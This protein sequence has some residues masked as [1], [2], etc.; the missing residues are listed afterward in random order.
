MSKKVIEN[1]KKAFHEYH[2]FERFDAGIVLVGT[3]IKSIRKGGV[4]LKDAFCKVEEGEL[5]LYSCHIA[6]YDKGNRFNHETQRVRKVLLHKK[7]IMKILG[8]VK[9]ENYTIIPLQMYLQNGFAKLEIAL[10]K[11]K[12]LY[13]KRD[14]LAKKS[15]QRDVERAMKR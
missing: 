14:D 7:E 5:W 13:D 15:I 11:G 3:E 1:N 8:K 4:S 12:K 10:C 2:I 9:K 6:P